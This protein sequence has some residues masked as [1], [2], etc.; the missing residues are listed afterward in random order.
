MIEISN[1]LAG[2]RNYDAGVKLYTQY[3][4]SEFYKKLFA[5]RNDTSTQARLADMLAALL[6]DAPAQNPQPVSVVTEATASKQTPKADADNKKYLDLLKRKGNLYTEL[7]FLMAQRLSLPDGDE[8]RDCA[9]QILNT[10]QKLRECW[11]QIDYYQDN[12]HFE[13]KHP[14]PVVVME[15]DQRAQYLRQSISKCKARLAAPGC[16]NRAATQKLLDERIAELATL[17]PKKHKTA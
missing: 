16:R 4:G 7:N 17:K 3:G 1:W 2:P 12:G 8:L 10:N 6:P 14:A 15:P 9:L 13:V 11:A 5:Q